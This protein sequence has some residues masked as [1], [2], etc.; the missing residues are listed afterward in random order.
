[1]ICE[2]GSFKKDINPNFMYHQKVNT[3]QSTNLIHFYCTE[4]H[5]DSKN[6][7]QFLAR[8]QTTGMNI[9]QTILRQ[10]SY[11]VIRQSYNW[12]FC[13]LLDYGT[14]RL[15][16][17]DILVFINELFKMFYMIVKSIIFSEIPLNLTG[18]VSN[19]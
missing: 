16:S 2:F 13:H 1:M 6:K 5:Q 12:K 18:L 19:N 3:L 4:Q 7:S 9:C 10:S 14:E 8:P 15:F 11:F 17:L